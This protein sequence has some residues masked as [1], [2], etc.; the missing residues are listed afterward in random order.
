MK[1]IIDIDNTLCIS[2]ERFALATKP[3]GKI[4]WDIAHNPELIEKDKPNYPMIDLAKKY[5]KDGF[6]VIV[7]TGRPESV[8]SVTEEWLKKYE[9]EYD[10]LIMRN[11]SSHFLKA[12]VYKK[13]VYETLIKSD[14]FC[15]YDDEEEI[16]QMWNSLGITA[17]KVYAID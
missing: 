13:K 14:V 7:L 16:I 3:N 11:R 15:A 17:F 9:I 1:V 8:E 6:E 10:R 2:N 5:K 12:V 4:D